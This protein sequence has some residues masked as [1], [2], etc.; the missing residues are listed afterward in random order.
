MYK[1]YNYY[2][3]RVIQKTSPRFSSLELEL[4]QY[5]LKTL[6]IY[7]SILIMKILNNILKIQN[8]K[9]KRKNFK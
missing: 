6:L 2:L 4:Q 3:I 9:D 7:C 5:F 8:N 1:Q